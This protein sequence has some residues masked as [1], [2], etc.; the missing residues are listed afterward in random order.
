MERTTKKIL[1]GCLIIFITIL[2]NLLLIVVA[3]NISCSCN[4]NK[5][6]KDGIEQSAI[7]DTVP[8]I[9]EQP[10]ITLIHFYDKEIDS[11]RFQIIRNGQLINDTLFRTQYTYEDGAYKKMEIPYNYFFKQIRL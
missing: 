6:K 11:I 1:K 7:C 10:E 8:Y 3:F 9:T 4:N 5:A 2:I